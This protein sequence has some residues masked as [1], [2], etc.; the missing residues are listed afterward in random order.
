MILITG[1]SDFE[2]IQAA[3]Q[4][5]VFDYILKPIEPQKVIG[6]VARAQRQLEVYQKHDRMYA[7]FQ[8]YFR[9]NYKTIKNQ[10]LEI[11]LF[12]RP[13][14]SNLKE[15]NS[16]FDMEFTNYRVVAV[17]CSLIL[18]CNNVKGGYYSTH[19]IEKH[20]KETIKGVV[21]YIWGDIMFFIWEVKKNDLFE[22]NIQ[23]VSFLKELRY[24]IKENCLINI[25]VG[26]SQA[27]DT[28]SNIQNL[29]KQAVECLEHPSE[30]ELN[31]F[32]FYE[33]IINSD[34][35]LWTM[36][37]DLLLLTAYVK[38]GNQEASLSTLHT[39]I[40]GVSGNSDEYI[41]ISYRLIITNITFLLH[42][43]KIGEAIIF[44]LCDPINSKMV[45]NIPQISDILEQWIKEVCH[46]VT[47]N[48]QMG[49]NTIVENIKEFIYSN[50]NQNIGL[51]EASRFVGRNPSYV[52]RLIKQYTN[53]NFTHILTE[54]RISE[55]KKLLQST[56][57]K[58]T[59]IAEKTGYANVHNYFSL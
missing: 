7:L 17:K 53:K 28:F 49:I 33:D 10:Y 8:E 20:V 44:Q 25:S 54:K 12:Q 16:L 6:S 24:H 19:I 36:E 22:D 14:H 48:Y 30:S 39:I 4:N 55:A 50:Y 58:V 40:H 41:L 56:N 45:R 27:T 57:M 43:L 13:P 32:L 29:R 3:I 9:N 5:Q 15:Q 59:A 23:L 52:S 51:T 42:E 35:M 47:E 46:T 34:Q 37:D 26:I 2:Y 31:F 1:Y 11:L 18:D 21:T 38:A